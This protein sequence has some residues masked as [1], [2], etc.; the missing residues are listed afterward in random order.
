MLEAIFPVSIV[1]AGAIAVGVG[2]F[3]SVG[4][5]RRYFHRLFEAR[6]APQEDGTYLASWARRR[7]QPIEIY[8]LDALTKERA[9]SYLTAG[10]V[11]ST[12]LFV[13]IVFA[14]VAINVIRPIPLMIPCELLMGIVA[15][16][17]QFRA[18]RRAGRLILTG[19]RV[20]GV[21]TLRLP[22]P[23]PEANVRSLR[24]IVL[25]ACSIATIG[26]AVLII[27]FLDP[28]S[29]AIDW[30]DGKILALIFLFV[31]L[32]LSVALLNWWILRRARS[33]LR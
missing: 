12:G 33:S 25:C 11:L 17:P 4:W 21:E 24:L 6:F 13:V 15:F 18:G 22:G 10:S 1:V 14:A 9:V 2:A 29:G 19:T 7:G 26:L 31:V 32:P 20:E 27:F 23:S 28:D 16:A 30:T 3:A 5:W 8:R